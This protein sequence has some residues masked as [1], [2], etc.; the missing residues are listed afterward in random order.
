LS[1]NNPPVQSPVLSCDGLFRHILNSTT[2]TKL[3]DWAHNSSNQIIID[4]F[5]WKLYKVGTHTDT[6]GTSLLGLWSSF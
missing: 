4:V 3:R 5:I 6:S 1:H 2:I